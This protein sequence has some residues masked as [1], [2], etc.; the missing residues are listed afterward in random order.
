MD[1]TL[2]L[3]PRRV[4]DFFQAMCAIPHGSGNTRAVSDYCAGVAREHG[5]WY[6]QDELG[7]LLIRRPADPGCEDREP[8]ILQAHLDM[9]WIQSPEAAGQG[10]RLVRDGDLLR[11]E[12]STLGADDGIGVAYV[13]A[14]LTQKEGPFP[15]LEG[16]LTV[17]EETSMEGAER[18]D[19]SLLQGRRLINLDSEEEGIL[20]AGAAGGVQLDVQADLKVRR[21]GL[22]QPVMVQLTLSGMEGGHSGMDIQKG[23]GNAIR[24]MAGLLADLQTQVRPT[25]CAWSGGS[26]PNAIA[27]QSRCTLALEKTA[28]EQLDR[29]VRQAQER[30]QSRF[31]R[32]AISLT[33]SQ[34]P[35]PPE[36]EGLTQ[37]AL[38]RLLELV[39]QVPDGVQQMDPLVPGMVAV[40]TNLGVLSLDGGACRLEFALRSNLPGEKEKLTEQV[41]ALAER[42]G[43]SLRAHGAYP[44]W[45]FRADSPLREA[46]CRVYRQLTDRSM[47]VT[48]IHAGTECSIFADRLPGLDCI[49]LGPDTWDV[50]STQERVSISSVGRVWT[51]LSALLR[52]LGSS[53]DSHP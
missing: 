34:M 29:L 48:T 11:A 4:F 27:A 47:E 53:A 2:N 24:E 30:L 45:T 1:Q 15:P 3:E 43:F 25:L 35:L 32:P 31:D 52:E 22:Q 28:L 38:S 19:C 10:I 26:F 46:A 50:H 13:L 7:N 41:R 12:S 14:L 8:V 33:W 37:A 51:F 42:E 20:L 5:L 44:E 40:S 36:G 17:D 9:V 23:R 6:R 18:F 16:L 21:P 49:S 39:R